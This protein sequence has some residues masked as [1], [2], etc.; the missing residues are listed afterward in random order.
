MAEV[1]EPYADVKCD[2]LLV[3]VDRS[4]HLASLRSFSPHRPFAEAML[5]WSGT[6]LPG[7]QKAVAPQWPAV[8]STFILAWRSPSEVW[9]LS[10]DAPSFDSLIARVGDITHG[11]C[12][13]QTGG[14]WVLKAGGARI[15]DMLAR[16]GSV[17]SMPAPGEAHV[18]RIAEVPV[19]TLSVNPGE[20]LLI[21][22]R[23][24]AEH[25]LGWIRATAADF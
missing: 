11:C 8:L 24:Y 15:A 20:V 7:S 18:T 17:A 2:G 3:Q 16:V 25:V 21:V 12:V 19:M 9:A 22:E 5:A 23:V 10:M 1:T 6:A 13:D 4:W 14:F